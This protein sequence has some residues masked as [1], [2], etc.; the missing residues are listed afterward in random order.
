MLL[1]NSPKIITLFLTDKNHQILSETS[2]VC[3]YQ[4]PQYVDSL[5]NEAQRTFSN[6][7]V[8]LAGNRYESIRFV[9]DSDKWVSHA[10]SAYKK[11]LREE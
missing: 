7:T 4:Y 10:E 11:C 6:D 5:I 2:I 1:T 9:S 8:V 3:K